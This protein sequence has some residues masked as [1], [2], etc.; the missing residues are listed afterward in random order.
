MEESNAEW[1]ELTRDCLVNILSRLSAR[2]QWL[3]AICPNLEV[4]SIRNCYV[5]DDCISKI[6][7][8]CPNLRELDISNCSEITHESFVL[9]GRNCFNLK[10]LKRNM[11]NKYRFHPSQ[12]NEVV[13]NNFLIAR[14][15]EADSEAA[16]VA[17][18]LPHLEWLEI[19]F[20]GL[21]AK[22]LKSICQGCPKS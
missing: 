11:R 17:N 18:S 20:L 3:G 13:P 5:S 1:A 21:T 10:V 9:L 8:G 4:L 22:G 2:D 6:S 12:H 14:M 16:A 19:S 15:Q 7:L